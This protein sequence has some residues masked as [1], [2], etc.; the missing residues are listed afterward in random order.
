[1]TLYWIDVPPGWRCEI[2]LSTGEVRPWDGANPIA[3]TCRF[4]VWHPSRRDSD[5]PWM[6][7]GDFLGVSLK[8]AAEDVAFWAKQGTNIKKG[9]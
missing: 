1:V 9:R 5:E 3:E 8:E 6:T 2:K 7:P 4:R